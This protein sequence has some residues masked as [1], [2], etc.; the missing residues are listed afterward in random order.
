MTLIV[1][2]GLAAALSPM[3][4]TEQTVL[5]AGPGGRRSASRYAL[6]TALVTALYLVVLVSWGHAISLPK[7][8]TLSASMDIVAGVLLL[9]VALA[10]Q[11]RH[12]AESGKPPRAAMAPGA[13]FGF[14]MFSMATNF[15]SLAVLLPAAK[16][17]A[18]DVTNLFVRLAL[19]AVL[20][21]L[22]TMPAWIPPAA[23]RVGRGTAQR[24]LEGLS[25]L[26]SRYGRRAAVILI[27]TLGVVLIAR[28]SWHI[29][30]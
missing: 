7:R 12:P 15:T 13:A 28:G 27:A 19:G 30:H 11:R 21:V 2:L 16:D 25:T 10:I 3:M 29:L 26:I 8:P 9:L 5:L 6:G 1:P 14:G 20:V 24:A 22:A 18:A 4:L 23:I 17:V